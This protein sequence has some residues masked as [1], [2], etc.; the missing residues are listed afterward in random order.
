MG[1]PFGLGWEDQM[2]LQEMLR[3]AT[4]LGHRTGSVTFDQL[5]ELGID[6]LPA[7][8]VEALFSALRDE[9]IEVTD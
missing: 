8:Q 3:L 9:G 5:G 6:E 4:E 1:V 2:D 7:E